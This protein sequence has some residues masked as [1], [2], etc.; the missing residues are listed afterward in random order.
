MNTMPPASTSP[1]ASTNRS[2]HFVCLAIALL[3]LWLRTGFPILAIPGASADDALFVHLARTL[4]AGHWLGNFDNTTLVKGMFYPLFILLAFIAGVPLPI[5]EQVVY[6][7]ACY[8]VAC[9]IRRWRADDGWFALVVFCALALN[10]EAWSRDLARVIRE[11][12]YLGL[13]LAVVGLTL[14]AS[15]PPAHRRPVLRGIAI[16]ILAG[17]AGGAFWLTREEGLW[18]APA[19]MVILGVA[20]FDSILGHGDAGF[21]ATGLARRLALRA[22]PWLCALLV[23]AA[24]NAF[25]AE[26]NWR[27]YGAFE[28]TEVQ[29]RN[30]RLGYD[31]LARIKP[32]TW[33]RYVVF[34]KDAR[35]KAYAVSSAARELKPALDGPI[36]DRWRAIGCGQQ[37]VKVCPEI[38]A[39][40]FQW[41]LRDAVAAAGHYDTAGDASAF[42]RTL[43]R[44]IDQACR[45]G[46][47][48]CS[49]AR[50]TLAPPFRWQYAG[51]A[52]RDAPQITLILLSLGGND[53]GPYESFTRPDLMVSFSDMVGPVAPTNLEPSTDRAVTHR[54]AIIRAITLRIADVYRVVMLVGAVTAC[55][56]LAIG[57]IWRRH[58]GPLPPA[59]VALALASV[60]AVVT[61]IAL[62][63]Y[64]DVTAIPSANS[65]YASPAS[66]FAI[67]FVLLGSFIG[68]RAVTGRYR[69]LQTR[70]RPGAEAGS[71]AP[72]TQTDQPDQ[73]LT[74]SAEVGVPGVDDPRFQI[75]K[76]PDVPSG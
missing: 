26:L 12:L 37:N 24:M 49:P 44:Q 56:G 68:Y 27:H 8:G 55:L 46:A 53:I 22:V 19:V 48:Q 74:S 59:L 30:F 33:Q 47:L 51:D 4:G 71:T 67:L 72:P 41:A 21:D 11:G 9:F 43:A 75:R 42:Y 64:L 65:L 52:L 38:L 39:G 2:F 76:M 16:G 23:L 18:L 3:S 36:G 57:V 6:L 70:P 1:T 61:R 10:P 15:F 14:Q 5:A 69:A 63:S 35:T 62:L 31:A 50:A 60:T 32:E 17:A 29:S 73:R 34:P 25:V 45:R 40:W 66:P 58:L 7:A 54:Q 13:S 20:V 28:T